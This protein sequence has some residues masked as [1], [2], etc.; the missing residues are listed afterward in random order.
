MNLRLALLPLALSMLGSACAKKAAPQ[1]EPPP[2]A[3]QPPV[4][5]QPAPA[6]TAMTS[7]ECEAEGGKVVGDIGDGAIH[8]PDYVCPDNGQ[9]P[10]GSIAPEGEGPVPVEGAV[11]CAA[12]P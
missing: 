5:E 2:G 3:E 7:A 10:I 11:C 4:D 8:R 6:R 9:P 12:A 1:S